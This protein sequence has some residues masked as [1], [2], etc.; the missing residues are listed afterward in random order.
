MQNKGYCVTGKEIGEDGEKKDIMFCREYAQIDSKDCDAEPPPGLT[1]ISHT[2]PYA[3]VTAHPPDRPPTPLLTPKSSSTVK[4]STAQKESTDTTTSST[5]REAPTTKD[6]SERGDDD[7]DLATVHKATLL[8][9]PCL[10]LLLF[11]LL[12]TP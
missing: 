4:D 8:L 11:S 9:A 5:T 6:G 1:T 12:A 7:S 3:N 10:M 2:I